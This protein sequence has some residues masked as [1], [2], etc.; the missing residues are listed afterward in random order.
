MGRP[1]DSIICTIE[2]Y[3]F[4]EARHGNGDVHV[5]SPNGTNFTF[6]ANVMEEFIKKLTTD[7][8]L[9]AKFGLK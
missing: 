3:Q 1:D 7:N 5:I 6:H 2:G 9:A 8:N 4:K